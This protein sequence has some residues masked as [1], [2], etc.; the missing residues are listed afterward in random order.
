M[1]APAVSL[2]D[3]GHECVASAAPAALPPRPIAP[4][5]GR[6]VALHSLGWL[7]A[8]NLVGLWLAVSLLWPAAGNALAPFTFGRWSPLHLDWQLYGWCSLPIVGALLAWCVDPAHRQARWHATIALAAWSTAL[9]L[10]GAGWLA[11]VGSG[12]LFLD[13]HGWSR[14]LLPAAQLILWLLLGLHTLRRWRQLSRAG[15]AL[16]A[17]VLGGLAI[18]P[19]I[20]YWTTSRAVYHPINPDSGGATG[21]AILGSSLGIMTIFLLLPVMLG[22]PARRGPRVV[23]ITLAASW[24]VFFALDRGNISHHTPLHIVALGTLLAWIPLLPYFWRRHEWPW[25][26]QP[27]L[28]AAALWWALLA[29]TGWISYLPGVSETYKFTHA[30]VAH[31]HL[32][33]AGLI[34]SV[35]G[36][37]LVVLTGRAAPRSSFWSWQLGCV[38]YLGAMWTLGLYET[39]HAGGLFRSAPVTQ[40]LMG[41]RLAGGLAMAAAS[42]RWLV[43]VSRS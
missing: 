18:V 31:A 32:A 23:L 42:I 3:C 27:W 10:G 15:R 43:S 35:N 26:A 29:V 21:A 36:A 20:L 33:M 17:V 5:F 30:L 40:L 13:W 38:V 9:A 39:T 24:V 1:N 37:V 16:R 34:T 12:K 4:V 25:P 2:R 22:V 8:A 19:G 14:P 6:A 7:V 11:G 28:V 41:L